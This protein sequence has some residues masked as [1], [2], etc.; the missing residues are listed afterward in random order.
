MKQIVNN[1][2]R[3]GIRIAVNLAKFVISMFIDYRNIKV[4]IYSVLMKE[5]IKDAY[6]SIIYE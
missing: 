2:P 5:P 1:S 6:V 3:V 4:Y